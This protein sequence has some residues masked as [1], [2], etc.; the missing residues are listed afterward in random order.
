MDFFALTA[1]LSNWM[2]KDSVC[3]LSRLEVVLFLRACVCV[4]FIV[5]QVY[6]AGLQSLP[7]PR[8][9]VFIFNSFLCIGF[10]FFAACSACFFWLYSFASQD[11]YAAF[12][13]RV[14]GGG[15]T[16]LFIISAAVVHFV[17]AGQGFA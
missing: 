11:K 6:L 7:A 15:D 4:F 3:L 9:T 17:L 2:P 14:F 8:F 16:C 5:F 1:A 10:E 13:A 12:A